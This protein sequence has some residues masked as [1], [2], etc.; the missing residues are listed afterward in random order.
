MQAYS[1]PWK[2]REVISVF[3]ALVLAMWLMDNFSSLILEVNP[4]LFF[5]LTAIIQVA[6]LV[7][8]V[9]YFVRKRYR[10]PWVYLGLA[11]APLKR[12]LV[13][14][15]GGGLLLCFSV[16]VLSLILA[17]FVSGPVEPQPFVE[18]L[19]STQNRLQLAVV[20]TVG[21]ILAPISEEIYFRGFFYPFLRK[22]LGVGVAL[23]G[24]ALIFGALHL[25]LIRFIPLT[26]GGYGLAWIYQRTGSLYAS[27]VAHSVWNT[28]MTGLV[29]GAGF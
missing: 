13:F 17:R 7:G 20:I 10:L 8:L 11:P 23:W 18:M 22:H 3:F 12:I 6:L 2:A 1:V 15:F 25:D 14:G 4:L 29:L 26:L 27:I 9:F 28:L 24:S 19:L 21:S 16:L 5:G